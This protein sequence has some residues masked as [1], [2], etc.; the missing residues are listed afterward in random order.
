MES[1]TTCFCTLNFDRKFECHFENYECLNLSPK[2][3]NTY[4]QLGIFDDAKHQLSILCKIIIIFQFYWAYG[5][6]SKLVPHKSEKRPI[7]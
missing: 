2:N 7:F 3:V 5:F 6:E 1:R 4:L